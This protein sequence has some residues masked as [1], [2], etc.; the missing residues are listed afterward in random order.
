MRK[1]VVCGNE[2]E[3]EKFRKRQIWYSHTCKECYAEQYRTGKPNLTRF[4]KGHI[5][6]IKGRKGIKKKRKPS[7]SEKNEKGT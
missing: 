3:L 1:C 4:K 6:W 7:I 2:K 5:P